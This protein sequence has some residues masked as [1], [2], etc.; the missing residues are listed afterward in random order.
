MLESRLLYPSLGYLLRWTRENQLLDGRQGS[1]C[2][3]REQDRGL[4]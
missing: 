1:L 2:D 4:L 3:G